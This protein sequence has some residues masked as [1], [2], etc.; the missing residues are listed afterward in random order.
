[1]VRSGR[2]GEAVARPALRGEP[3]L[4]PL[5]SKDGTGVVS[6]VGTPPTVRAARR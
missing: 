2:S 4:F 5:D 1:M 6:P 3:L